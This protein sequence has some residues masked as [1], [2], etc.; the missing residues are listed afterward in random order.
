[1]PAF[2]FNYLLVTLFIRRNINR[3][4]A[5]ALGQGSVFLRLAK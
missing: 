3:M 2:P 5:E 4:C 1:M